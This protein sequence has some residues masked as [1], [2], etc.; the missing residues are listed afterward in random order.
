MF[1]YFDELDHSNASHFFKLRTATLNNPVVRYSENRCMD[2]KHETELQV[3]A[4]SVE[5]A[6]DLVEEGNH[7]F[8]IQEDSLA[9]QMSKERCNLVYVSEGN[10]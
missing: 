10:Y 2:L 7:I 4:D 5:D 3:V 6:L 9:M 1:R 8:P